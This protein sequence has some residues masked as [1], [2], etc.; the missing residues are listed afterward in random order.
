ME[1][2]FGEGFIWVMVDYANTAAKEHALLNRKD[3]T[4]FKGRLPISRGTLK[5]ENQNQ[6]AATRLLVCII[7]AQV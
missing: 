6:D 7:G 5:I 2:D 3:A 4:T 1:T